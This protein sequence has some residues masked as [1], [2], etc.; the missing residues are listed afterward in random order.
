MSSINTEITL[1]SVNKIL[2]PTIKGKKPFLTLT[3]TD[4][5]NILN[6][7][8]KDWR[9]LIRLHFQAEGGIKTNGGVSKWKPLS[10]K[11]KSWKENNEFSD[12]ILEL[13]KPT[14]ST[15]YQRS[16]YT[17]PKNFQIYITYPDLLYPKSKNNPQQ[18]TA[19]VHQPQGRNEAPQPGQVKR[20][21][22]K[23]SFI[24]AA[25]KRI[26]EYLTK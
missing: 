10:E 15:R 14:L 20:P 7:I 1:I 17:N 6:N 16:I 22:I 11:Y 13:S 8:K 3:E 26:R 21:I 24:L 19:A 23:Q 5:K 12:N 2:G 9:Q 18:V 4:K 25:K